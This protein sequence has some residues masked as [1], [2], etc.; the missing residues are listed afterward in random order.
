MTAHKSLIG[1]VINKFNH[2]EAGEV[3]LRVKIS[4]EK[5]EKDAIKVN[6]NNKESKDCLNFAALRLKINFERVAVLT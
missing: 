4:I 3:C 1:W 5:V 6:S 2:V